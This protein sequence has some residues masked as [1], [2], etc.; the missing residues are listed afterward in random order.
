MAQLPKDFYGELTYK[1]ERGFRQSFYIRVFLTDSNEIVM[2][3]YNRPP[4]PGE[5]WD[6]A[7]VGNF[8][9]SWRIKRTKRGFFLSTFVVSFIFEKQDVECLAAN[10]FGDMLVEGL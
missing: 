5:S 1:D 10:R 4:S 2:R 8:G 9:D 7:W 6:L 3:M